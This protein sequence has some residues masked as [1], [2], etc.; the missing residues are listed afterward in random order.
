MLEHV[1]GAP[2]HERE[3]RRPIPLSDFRLDFDFTV[4]PDGTLVLLTTDLQDQM[5]LDFSEGE[6]GVLLL[7]VEVSGAHWGQTKY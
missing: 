3:R 6:D 2:L 4:L 1:D 7:E 5:L